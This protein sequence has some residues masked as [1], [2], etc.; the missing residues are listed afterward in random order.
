MVGAHLRQ[1]DAGIAGAGFYDER[2]GIDLAGL[3]RPFNNGDTGTILGTATRIQTFQL[4]E[5]IEM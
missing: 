1:P 5:A 2:A 3:Q 4:R